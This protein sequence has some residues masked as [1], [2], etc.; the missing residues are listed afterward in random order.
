M[1]MKVERTTYNYAPAGSF[2]TLGL[3]I[4]LPA[5]VVAQ[6]GITAWVPRLDADGAARR[7]VRLVEAVKKAN[8]VATRTLLKQGVDVNA[9]Q[10]DGA[11]ALHWAAYWDDQETARLLIRAGA[12]LNAANDLGVTPL[13]VACANGSTAIIETLVKAGADA[14]AAPSTG[15][16]PLMTASRVGNVEAVRLLLAHGADPNVKE[17]SHGQTA[18][19]WAVAQQHSE[20]VQV[21]IEAGAD[22]HARSHVWRQLMLLC[23]QASIYDQGES[24]EVE[25]GG[26]TPLLFAARV[27]DVESAR[28]LLAA[29][30]N[31]N[32][33]TPVGS[34]ALVVAAH[35]GHGA[36]GAFLLDNGADPNATGAG[37]TAL[38]AAVLRGD[39][40]LV[41]SLLAHGA[42]PNA[43]LTTGTPTRRHT[44]D[45]AF[46]KSWIGAT[47]FWLAARFAEVDIIR[48]LAGSG[49]HSRLA[50]KDGTT[51]LIA[52]AQGESGRRLRGVKVGER[53][54]LALEAV[55]LIVALGGDVN[56]ANQAGDTALHNAALRRMDTVVQFLVDRGAAL[57]VRNEQGQTPLMLAMMGSSGPNRNVGA[58]LRSAGDGRHSSTGDLLRK[59]GAKE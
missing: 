8:D 15:E 5:T 29:G 49:A 9:P 19:M 11:T 24:V 35:S 46:N 7:D 2:A 3:I 55:K 33:A 10:G 40:E 37:Y 32:D 23:C 22:L 47:P 54:R 52:A 16:T 43:P 36:L 45:L 59:L 44:Q 57:D 12:A 28:P 4:L 18:L 50:T 6:T 39:S 21:L 53:E 58:G 14:N 51:P 41:K 20:V 56:A 30:A 48:V 25:Q 17:I 42:N 26:G 1:W 38:H 34:T 31:V 13:W 27:G